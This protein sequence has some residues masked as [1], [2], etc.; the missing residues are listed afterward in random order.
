MF[1]LFV[2]HAAGLGGRDGLDV[3]VHGAARVLV[4]RRLPGSEASRHLGLGN[5]NLHRRR[6]TLNT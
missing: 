5:V 6:D 4:G 3:A 2:G 1:N